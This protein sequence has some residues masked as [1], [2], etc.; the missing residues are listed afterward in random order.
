MNKFTGPNTKYDEKQSPHLLLN[1]GFKIACILNKMR[2]V[3]CAKV[4]AWSH[5]TQ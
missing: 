3:K 4:D 5:F 2:G 1:V